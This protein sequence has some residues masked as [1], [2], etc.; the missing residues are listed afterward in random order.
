V[1]RRA[2]LLAG[3]GAAAAAVAVPYA[4]LVLGDN[5]EQLVADTLGMDTAVAS[6][7]L[8]RLREDLGGTDYEQRAAAFAVAFAGP[9]AGAVPGGLRQSA[10]D[11]FLGP[12]F[13]RPAERLAYV[14]DREP[15]TACGGLLRAA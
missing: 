6:A 2:F 1:N 4:P 14:E 10:L 8:E 9:W 11:R 5:F 12:L 7:L 15:V 3:A 13:E